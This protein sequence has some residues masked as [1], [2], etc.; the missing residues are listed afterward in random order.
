MRRHDH[1]IEA[2]LECQLGA[3]ADFKH[4][5]L[6]SQSQAVGRAHCFPSWLDREKHAASGMLV[7]ACFDMQKIDDNL[8][9]FKVLHGDCAAC[10]CLN[11]CVDVS[12]GVLRV[13]CSSVLCGVLTGPSR[14]PL[15]CTCALPLP[16]F[17][18]DL[19]GHWWDHSSW[20]SSEASPMSLVRHAGSCLDTDPD[21]SPPP[22]SLSSSLYVCPPRPQSL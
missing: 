22:H 20:H 8:R 18:G 5:F 17:T 15:L 3:L 13:L 14:C 9:G 21:P 10:A 2:S 1:N 6:I 7:T 19:D 11:E 16:E 12:V 4:N